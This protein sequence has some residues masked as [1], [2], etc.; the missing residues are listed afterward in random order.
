MM[1][2]ILNKSH[3]CAADEGFR[4]EQTDSGEVG[5]GDSPP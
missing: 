1:A 4:G 2:A 3:S 5:L